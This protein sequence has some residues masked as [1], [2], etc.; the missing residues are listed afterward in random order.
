VGGWR[1]NA[2]NRVNI[3]RAPAN[4]GG[5]GKKGESGLAARWP[6]SASAAPLPR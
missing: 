3:L 1:H 4:L 6:T 2:L 5:T